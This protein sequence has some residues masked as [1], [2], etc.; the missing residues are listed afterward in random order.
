MRVGWVQSIIFQLTLLQKE[1]CKISPSLQ[2]SHLIFMLKIK[3]SFQCISL[4]KKYSVASGIIL[5]Y[6]ARFASN[7][8]Y[9]W[10]V[11]M[12]KILSKFSINYFL[13]P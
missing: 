3:F 4:K 13:K 6:T 8:Y 11:C 12:Y 5:R 1:R 10:K 2:A 9:S 7:L